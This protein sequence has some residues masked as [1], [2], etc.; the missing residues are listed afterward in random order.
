VFVGVGV[1][2]AVPVGVRV[3]VGVLVPV[4]VAVAVAVLVGVRVAVAV[5][6]SVCVGVH[7]GVFVAAAVDV[8]VNVGVFA[9]T[10]A[11]IAASA[12]RRGK[13]RPLRP[14]NSGTPVLF[15]IPSSASALS[16]GSRESSSA[17]VPVACGAAIE[18]P[19]RSAVE[20][21]RPVDL[22]PSG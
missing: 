8:A 18:V 7:V 22:I 2:V 1:G 11:F 9:F 5:S 3:T 16:V 14:S 10:T 17:A 20:P 13:I 15:R 21:P 12:S 4:G 6:A 19:E